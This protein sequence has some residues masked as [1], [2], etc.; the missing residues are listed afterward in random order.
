MIDKIKITVAVT[1][2]IAGLVAYYRFAEAAL[3]SGVAGA[4]GVAAAVA[5]TRGLKVVSGLGPAL[6]PLGNFV[7][8][9][10]VVVAGL[11]LSLLVGLLSGLLPALG[12]A[13]KPV[14][15]ALREV[16]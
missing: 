10:E 15:E 9:R 7:V 4:L 13:R 16:F 6:G 12:A 8:T 1:C 3:L 11:S 2:V 14:V 5:L